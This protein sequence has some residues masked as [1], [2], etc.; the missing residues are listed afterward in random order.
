MPHAKYSMTE[1]T[2]HPLY[3]CIKIN[4]RSSLLAAFHICV[5]SVCVG[6]APRGGA[7]YINPFCAVWGSSHVDDYGSSGDQSVSLRVPTH[8][9]CLSAAAGDEPRQE[10][11][12]HTSL[13]LISLRLQGEVQQ[14]LESLG[15]RVGES[16]VERTSR[17][18]PRFKNELDAVVFMCKQFWMTAFNKNI[19]NLKTNHQVL[20]PLSPSVSICLWRLYDMVY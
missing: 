20:L 1:C 9:D 14:R 13:S 8:G 4:S 17:D 16:L 15:H 10:G 18:H 19:D 2:H 6:G 7:W 5:N 12:Y 3:H 11:Q